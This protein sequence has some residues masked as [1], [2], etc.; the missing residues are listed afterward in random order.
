M[1]DFLPAY[2][3]TMLAEGGYKLTN[4]ANDNGGQTYAGI[5]RKFHPTW[6]GWRFIDGGQTPPTDIVR[7]FYRTEFW[8]FIRGDQI[9]EQAIADSL[10]DFSI[11]AGQNT[12]VKLAQVVLGVTP[13]GTVG[14]KTLE[15]INKEE[16]DYFRLSFGMAKITRYRD[17]VVKDRTQV[18][19]LVGWIN[20]VI[21]GLE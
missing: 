20:R 17:I 6:P 4:A 12:A 1:A 5:S 11:N 2:E 3:K 9:K 18:K 19:W 15:A 10:Y 16:V 13:D 8:D 14:P 21:K 7:S